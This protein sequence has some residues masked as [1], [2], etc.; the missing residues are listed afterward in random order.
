MQV[1]CR[2]KRV[3]AANMEWKK[4]ERLKNRIYWWMISRELEVQS[5]GEWETKDEYIWKLGNEGDTRKENLGMLR[6]GVNIVCSLFENLPNCMYTYNLCTLG[7]YVT[8]NKTFKWELFLDRKPGTKF[9][10]T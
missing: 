6:N 4:A 9:P 10:P 2:N 1:K 3:V 7:V 8:I 5:K